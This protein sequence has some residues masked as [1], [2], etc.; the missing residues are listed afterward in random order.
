MTT[1]I[2]NTRI[3]E[4]KNVA[5]IW[6]EGRKVEKAGVKIGTRY[7]LSYVKG[8]ERL[9]LREA[10]SNTTEQT[11]T[12]SKRE[13]RGNVVPLMEVRTKVLSELFENIERVRVAIRKGRIV[14]TALHLETKV[15][16]RVRRMVEK[17]RTGE[18]LA[19]ASLFSGGGVMDRALHAGL[20]RA[21]INAFVQVGVELEPEY[22]DSSLENNREIWSESSVVIC[23]DIREV[24]WGHNP[25]QCD[26]L[27]AGIP[28]S[29]ASRSGRS[30]GKLSSAE[31]H[32][33]VGALFVDYLEAVKALN[34]AVC[35][36]ENVPEYQNA[37][38]MIVIR[39][40]LKTLG[41]KIQERVLDG[42]DFGALERRRRM[43][44]VATSEGLSDLFDLAN[45]VP[46][47]NKPA[48]IREI[49]ED[50][51]LDSPRYKTFEYLADK[52][53]RDKAAGKG[54]TRQLLTGEEGYCGTIGKS[55]FK[56]RS[57]EPFLM[58]PVDPK[59]SRLLTPIEHA[60]VK[61]IPEEIISGLS[62]TVAHEILGQ[63][64]IFPVFEAIGLELGIAI[65][66]E[67]NENIREL[68]QHGIT[69]Y[70]QQICGSGNCG[71]GEVCQEGINP[72]TQMPAVHNAPYQG[73]GELVL[74]AA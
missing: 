62:D 47:K 39:S 14:I 48:S 51:P 71:T 12:V 28:C 67:V 46:V 66:G 24:N 22:L 29:G 32:E 38:S 61:G 6:L 41:Y 7:Q 69:S 49:L 11:F 21:G 70:C 36:I 3:G 44:M 1:T 53:V 50:V 60:R 30:K 19:V 9:E 42:N 73:Q 8:M 58:H 31:A 26:L 68:L 63:S 20:R 25:P 52:E 40:V 13:R 55:Y 72:Q 59:L 35:L 16:E 23:S 65:G 27:Y 37:V 56:C 57:T 10:A 2:I 5:R 45:V 34:P 33:S 4:S 18:P 74:T 17:L 64:V 15:K 54:F 43:V